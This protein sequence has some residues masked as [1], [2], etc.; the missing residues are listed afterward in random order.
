MIVNVYH[1]TN[2]YFED[3][4]LTGDIGFHFGNKGAAIDRLKAI[5][6]KPDVTIEKNTYPS[7]NPYGIDDSDVNSEDSQKRALSIIIPRLSN[8]NLSVIKKI[9]SVPLAELDDLIQEYL[10]KP[11]SPKY[12]KMLFN[13]GK[14]DDYSVLIDGSEVDLVNSKQEA[15]KIQAKI[16]KSF[17]KKA[18]LTLRNPLR[19][20]DLGTWTPHTL[21]NA[22]ELSHEQ[23]S[24]VLSKE[25]L[26]ESYGMLRAIIKGRGYDGIV[27][28]NQVEGTGD[29]Y[30]AFSQN[31]ILEIKCEREYNK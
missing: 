4:T 27:Y 29:S 23:L 21:C 28:D 15:L 17:F 14:P 11:I 9:K 18:N 26:D 16:K 6:G 13:I 7:K 24:E 5:G 30:I 1:S 22:L 19:M 2:Q 20:E 25:D 3:F 10:E 8:P 12:Q 31:D